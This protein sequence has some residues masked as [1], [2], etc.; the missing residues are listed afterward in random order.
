VDPVVR[1]EMEEDVGV[2]LGELYFLR[3][4]VLG[5]VILEGVDLEI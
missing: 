1:G 4:G 5:D 3:E 2:L